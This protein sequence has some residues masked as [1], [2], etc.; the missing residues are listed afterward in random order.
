MGV[1]GGLELSQQYQKSVLVLLA[2]GNQN[3]NHGTKI[4]NRPRLYSMVWKYGVSTV[5]LLSTPRADAP[6]ENV[7]G[8]KR[9]ALRIPLPNT[10]TG[11][12]TLRGVPEPECLA[13]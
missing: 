9:V 6:W 10:R 3:V 5:E 12:V 4:I 13:T 7:L 8:R 1:G 2:L 11:Y